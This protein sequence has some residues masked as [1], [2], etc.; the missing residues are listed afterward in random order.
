MKL[1][2]KNIFLKHLT[3]N[4]PRGI[5][6]VTIKKGGKKMERILS[7]AFSLQMLG[8]KESATLKVLE[9]S[10]NFVS[11]Q[12]AKGFISAV[13]HADTAAVISSTL[14]VDV[15]MNRVNVT[16]TENTDLYVAQVTGGRLPEGCVTLPEGITIKFYLVKLV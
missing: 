1:S 6:I 8:E 4:A 10:R 9:V 12:L 11:A 14:G 13:G 5:I 7:N 3:L 16:L 15:E 2:E